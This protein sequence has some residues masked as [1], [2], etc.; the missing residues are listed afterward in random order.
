MV[1][2]KARSPA[3]PR[4]MKGTERNG[5]SILCEQQDC[6]L[7]QYGKHRSHLDSPDLSFDRGASGSA[8]A[9]GAVHCVVPPDTALT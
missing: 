3:P 8:H 4:L 6:E 7:L 2:S 5:D 1:A 9:V